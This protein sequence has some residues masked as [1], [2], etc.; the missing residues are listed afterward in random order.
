M[1]ISDIEGSYMDSYEA[2][3]KKGED[4]FADVH[5]LDHCIKYLNQSLVALGFP[6]GLS[7]YSSDPVSTAKTCNCIYSM[8]QQRQRDIEYREAANETRQRLMSDMSRL[9]AKMERLADQLSSKERELQVMA[10]KEQKMATAFKTQLE[11]LQQE[12]DEF[13]RMLIATQQVRSQ[14]NHELK[15]K[16]KEYVKL[17]ERLNQV[18]MEKKKESKNGLEMIHLLQKEGRQRGTWNPKKTDGDFYKMIVDA[19]ESKKQELVAENADLRALLRSMQADMRDSLNTSNGMPRSGSTGN[20]SVDLEPPP[21]PLQGRTD[22][23]DL[24]FH[25]ARDQIEQSLRAKMSSIKERMMQLQGSQNEGQASVSCARV[26]QLEEQLPE[27]RSII[28]EQATLM[29]KHISESTDYSV[30]LKDSDKNKDANTISSGETTVGR[31]EEQ[32]NSEMSRVFNREPIDAQQK[33]LEEQVSWASAVT[34]MPPDF[35]G[36]PGLFDTKKQDEP[37]LAIACPDSLMNDKE[38]AEN[39]TATITS[40]YKCPSNVDIPIASQHSGGGVCQ[41]PRFESYEEFEHW[42]ARSAFGG[43]HDETMVMLQR[44]QTVAIG[45]T[46]SSNESRFTEIS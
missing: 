10:S 44:T 12:K 4:V 3:Y 11:K 14:Q 23:F 30:N 42:I 17:Q 32:A 20:G 41:P 9:E 39:I 35:G 8:I 38:T 1:K 18:V 28:G 24:P 22:V 6:S 36:H 46:V 16:E 25:M 5:N 13:Q 40:E 31:G 15:K 7:L 29:S 19:Y 21:T 34:S 37:E 33:Y 2:D 27:T 26:L 45:S 43:R